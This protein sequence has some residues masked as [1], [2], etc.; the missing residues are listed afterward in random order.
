[1]EK[2]T[3]KVTR[4]KDSRL[5]GSDLV[6]AILI[7]LDTLDIIKHSVDPQHGS[8]DDIK[9]EAYVEYMRPI[10]YL[11]TRDAGEIPRKDEYM[12]GPFAQLN[13]LNDALD[14]Q[15]LLALLEKTIKGLTFK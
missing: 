2:L 3:G 15:D 9:Y 1:M 8:F 10:C 6:G 13:R 12:Y 14:K 11:L 5:T 4:Y 7:A